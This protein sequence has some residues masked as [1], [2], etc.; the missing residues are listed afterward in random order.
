MCF[1][2]LWPQRDFWLKP[3]DTSHTT[4]SLPSSARSSF[5]PSVEWQIALTNEWVRCMLRQRCVS[6]LLIKVMKW[7]SPHPCH[8]QHTSLQTLCLSLV[9]PDV[10]RHVLRSTD[11]G[12]HVLRSCDA[13]CWTACFTVFWT[14]KHRCFYRVGFYLETEVP[15]FLQVQD[16]LFL[17]KNKAK[18]NQCR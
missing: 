10:R 1:S 8:D 7:D 2:H 9:M 18:E 14:V 15:R 17:Y 13:R 5:D 12:R 11:V 16:L 6:R 3:V 4:T